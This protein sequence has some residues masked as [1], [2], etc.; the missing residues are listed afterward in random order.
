MATVAILTA[1]QVALAALLVTLT[2]ALVVTAVQ[3][4]QAATLATS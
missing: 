1:V 4:A 3:L 2:A